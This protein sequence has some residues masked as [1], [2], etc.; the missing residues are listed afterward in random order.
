[1]AIFAEYAADVPVKKIAKRYKLSCGS[2]RS[3]VRTVRK[4]GYG[5]KTEK[6]KRREE[7]RALLEAPRPP[8]INK[9]NERN[10]RIYEEK[11][12]WTGL[13][14]DF[15]LEATQKYGLSKQ[16]IKNIISEE[17][18]VIALSENVNVLDTFTYRELADVYQDVYRDYTEGVINGRP[19][20]AL[21]ESLADKYGYGLPNIQRI[22]SIMK[23]DNKDCKKQYKRKASPDVVNRD[24]ELFVDFLNWDGTPGEFALWAQGKYGLTSDYVKNIVTLHYKANPKRY[25]MIHP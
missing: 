17:K 22:I 7:R 19:K 23:S 13:P 1:M 11:M 10:R 5:Y 16:R 15:Y 9:T 8:H 25:D 12:A 4:L 6:E 20:I 18:R 21:M 3:I 14:E 2:I 24:K